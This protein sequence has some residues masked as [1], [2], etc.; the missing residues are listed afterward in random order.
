[1]AAALSVRA[2]TFSAGVLESVSAICPNSKAGTKE[3]IKTAE[4]LNDFIISLLSEM[5]GI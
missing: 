4:N 2:A 1:V 5:I 3:K